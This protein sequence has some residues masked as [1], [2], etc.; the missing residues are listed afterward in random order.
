MI[1]ETQIEVVDRKQ[2]ELTGVEEIM[3]VKLAFNSDDI[4][5][6][7]QVIDDNDYEVNRKK[8]QIY[9]KS[10]EYFTIYTTYEY[11][12]EVIKSQPEKNYYPL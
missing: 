9:L 11:V 2:Q 12:L 1:I 3:Y 4:S 6:V 7:R 10:G 8:C 5:A